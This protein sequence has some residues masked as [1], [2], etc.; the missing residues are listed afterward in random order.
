MALKRVPVTIII[1]SAVTVGSG[2]A[3]AATGAVQMRRAK[4]ANRTQAERY[5][6][7]YATHKT[8]VLRTNE[9][10]QTFGETQVR[11]R[12]EVTFRVRD[13]L[14]RNAKQGHANEHLTSQSI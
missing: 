3:A 7:R 14:E 12:N 11:A 8:V 2:V 9:R 13:F 10:L 1:G 6:E 5:D 4:R